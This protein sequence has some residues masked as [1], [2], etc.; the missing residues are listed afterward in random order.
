MFVFTRRQFIKAGAIGGLALIAARAIN[1][2]FRAEPGAA[3]DPGHAYA[4]LDAKARATIAA[5]APVMLAGALPDHGE[6]RSRAV[7]DVVRGVDVAISGL[8]PSVQQEVQR[9]FMLLGVAPMRRLLAR[10]A[11]PWLE[12]STEDIARFLE[13][14]RHSP[15]ALLR[16]GYQ[17]L[18][19]LILAAWYGNAQSWERIG[20]PGPPAYLQTE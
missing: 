9:L 20:Y 17:A 16:S 11:Q 6:A 4:A 5:I 14:W 7:R 19:E 13:R 2:P 3:P 12:A 10:V 18:H 1:G 15:I 8:S